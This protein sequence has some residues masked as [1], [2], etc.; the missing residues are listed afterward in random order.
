MIVVEAAFDSLQAPI[1]R[2]AM[3]DIPVPSSK[4]LEQFVI[5]NEKDIIYAVKETV[6]Y[7]Q[8]KKA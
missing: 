2:V 4:Y 3:P 5:P 6:N 8:H 1:R 7:K